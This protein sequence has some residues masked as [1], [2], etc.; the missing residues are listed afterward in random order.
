MFGDVHGSFTVIRFGEQFGI[1]E[2]DVVDSTVFSCVDTELI[3]ESGAHYSDI[4]LVD[5]TILGQVIG[6][7]L[8]V[9]FIV[10]SYN[11]H[12]LS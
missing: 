3:L 7:L 4:S 1:V 6:L 2:P 10:R 8:L 9:V 11:I 5:K 12:L